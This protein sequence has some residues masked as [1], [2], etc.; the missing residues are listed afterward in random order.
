MDIENPYYQGSHSIHRPTSFPGT[1]IVASQPMQIDSPSTKRFS[2]SQADFYSVA[3]ADSWVPTSP[4][5]TFSTTSSTVVASPTNQT[6][7]S[8]SAHNFP[9]TQESLPAYNSTP[10]LIPQ[11]LSKQ[12]KHADKNGLGAHHSSISPGQRDS[13][14]HPRCYQQ[15]RE[16]SPDLP[17]IG[18]S[19]EAKEWL[20]QKPTRSTTRLIHQYNFQNYQHYQPSRNPTITG[21]NART[22]SNNLNAPVLSI[23]PKHGMVST[24]NGHSDP[25]TQTPF[26]QKPGCITIAATTI[27]S[28]DASTAQ[29]WTCQDSPVPTR[30]TQKHFDGHFYHHGRDLSPSPPLSHNLSQEILG[31]EPHLV[32]SR[33]KISSHSTTTVPDGSPGSVD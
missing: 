19:P 31:K 14:N 30:F 11:Q 24:P 10:M 17:L 7:G 21:Y 25:S 22:I 3:S 23:N 20:K 2:E 6:Y 8:L 16:F 9:P 29:P 28:N 26:K 33:S 18:T 12:D 5:A 32:M 4:T 13:D 15:Q 1:T 27:A